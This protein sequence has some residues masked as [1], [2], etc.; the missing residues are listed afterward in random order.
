[1][2]S[3]ENRAKGFWPKVRKTRKGCWLWVGPKNTDGY[4]IGPRMQ[5]AHRISFELTKGPIP[6]GELVLHTCDNPPCVRPDHLK[7]GSH[8]E[9]LLDAYRKGRLRDPWLIEIVEKGLR[10]EKKY[11]PTS[12]RIH[13]T[14]CAGKPCCVGTSRS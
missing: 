3:S 11:G 7:V 10:M 9:N 4:G 1:M 14:Q 13:T 8:Y 5:P 6:E 12:A 2:S